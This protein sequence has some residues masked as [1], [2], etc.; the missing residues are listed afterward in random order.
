MAVEGKQEVVQS[1]RV[2]VVQQQP[3]AYAAFCGKVYE[4]EQ[5]FAGN[6]VAPD[7]VLQIETV[8]GGFNEGC[9]RG[10]GFVGIVQQIDI[11]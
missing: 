1:A 2:V 9:A 3:Y 7:V 4:V 5:K 11:G 6:I 8:F 10:K